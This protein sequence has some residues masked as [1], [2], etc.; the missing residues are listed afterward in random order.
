MTHDDIH[1]EPPECPT[2]GRSGCHPEDFDRVDPVLG[3]LRPCP[4]CDG[5]G[6]IQ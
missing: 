2:C 1:D 3:D 5:R 4:D 6:E